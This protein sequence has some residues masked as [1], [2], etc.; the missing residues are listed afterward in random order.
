M[1][2]ELTAPEKETEVYLSLALSPCRS[3]ISRCAFSSGVSGDSAKGEV[4]DRS[5]VG[6]LGDPV[7]SASTKRT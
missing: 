2:R 6:V 7:W 1:P 4:L 5:L 3:A